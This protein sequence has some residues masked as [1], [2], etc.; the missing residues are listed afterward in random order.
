MQLRRSFASKV[1][2]WLHWVLAN[3]IGSAVGMAIAIAISYL[4]LTPALSEVVFP[5]SF[6]LIAFFYGLLILFLVSGL[7]IGSA[8]GLAQWWVLRDRLPH[9]RRWAL[10]QRENRPSPSSLR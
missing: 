2:L 8:V 4:L 1:K 3:G 10:V 5:R 6:G 9:P 7:S